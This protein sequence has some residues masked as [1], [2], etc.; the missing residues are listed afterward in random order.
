MA[1][2]LLVSIALYNS[3]KPLPEDISLKGQ[4]YS[5][6]EEDIEFLFDLTYHNKNGEKVIE[7]NIFDTWFEL[8]QA[9]ER[10]IIIDAFLFNNDYGI[11]EEH[12]PLTDQLKNKLISKREENP[13]IEITF[14]TDPINDF[15]GSYQS[16]ELQDLKDSGIKVIVTDL[17][18]LRDS[19]PYYSSVWRLFLQWFGTRGEGWIPHPLNARDK[20]VTLRSFLSLLNTKA[21]HRKLLVADH[22]DEI[23]TIVSSGNPHTASSLHSNIAF[24][25]KDKLWKDAL[26]AEGAVAEMSGQT[27]EIPDTDFVKEKSAGDSVSAQFLTEGKIKE[28]LSRDIGSLTKGDSLDI[29]VFYLSDRNVIKRIIKAYQRGVRVRLILD[30]NKDAFGREKN[31]IPNRQVVYEIFRETAGNLPIRWYDTRGEQFH[32]KLIILRKSN[33]VLI[34][35]GSANLTR[36]NISDLNLESN[37]KVSIPSDSKLALEISNYFERIWENKD[38][39]YTLSPDSFKEDSQF[40]Y[41][42]YRFQEA[43]GFSSF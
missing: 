34:Y 24:L 22:G 20:K 16:K 23:W 31:G 14:I 36:R 3:W 18:K 5:V 9:A 43:T 21:N 13:K 28:G 4:S 26:K 7:Q 25:I 39:K 1:V 33:N 38:G 8:V 6:M 12:V 41:W 30:P 27:V 32:T 19:N 40:K 35:S 17:T 2:I 11:K 29:A 37:I 15:Y 10:F 42:L